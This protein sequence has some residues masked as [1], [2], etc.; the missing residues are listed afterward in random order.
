M[1]ERGGSWVAALAVV[2][3]IGLGAAVLYLCLYPLKGYDQPRG[4][5]TA[6]YLWR[7]SCVE[8][9]GVRGLRDCAPSTQQ[10][11][12]GRV[13]YPLVSLTLSGTLHMSRVTMAAI[14]P[15]VLAAAIALA[16]A[17]LVS[18]ALGVGSGSFMVVAVV[19]GASPLVIALATPEGY[20][21]T[22]IALALGLGGL[23]ALGEVAATGRGRAGAATLLGLMAVV[24]WATGSI[25]GAAVL[26]VTAVAFVRP[27]SDAPA[28]GRRMA[29]AMMGAV[30]VW[31]F[32]LFALVRSPPDRFPASRPVFAEKLRSHVPRLGLPVG[33]LAAAVG[34]AGTWKG[35]WRAGVRRWLLGMLMGAWIAVIAA[36]LL[37]WTLGATLPIHRFLGVALPLPILGAVALLWLVDALR[38]RG[39]AVARTAAVVGCVVVVAV[40]AALWV[41]SPR[42]VMRT[43]R[44][45]SAANAAAY[46]EA[47]VPPGTQVSVIADDPVSKLDILRQ[48]FRSAIPA[49]RIASVAFRPRGFVPA[50]DGGVAIA[51][52]GYTKGFDGIAESHPDAVLGSDVVVLAGPTPAIASVTASFDALPTNPLTLIVLGVGT[53]VLLTLTGLGWTLAGLPRLPPLAATGVAPAA[54]LA[55]LVGAG[56][57]ADALGV[58][59]S[60]TPALFV[61]A[62]AG[63]LGWIAAGVGRRIRAHAMHAGGLPSPTI[64][65]C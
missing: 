60:P 48:T 21:D 44:I 41:R 31:A 6:R 3:A 37:A 20:A 63:A 47:A 55:A 35:P 33:V 54:G 49:A 27:P 58:R 18:G 42:P 40:G 5:D 64:P 11:L 12:P 16:A 52:R 15:P 2:A 30:A 4:Y 7:T 65:S 26:A 43:E 59:L 36:A 46:L 34:L 38:R 61:T 39:A 1:S 23:V 24:H 50:E 62:A 17:A 53:F 28:L 57:V 56:L 19:V 14:L 10:T 25:L 32:G 29:V 22:M 13:G 51:V 8:A 9:G 45:R